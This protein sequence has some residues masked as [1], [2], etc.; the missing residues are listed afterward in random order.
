MSVDP[1]FWSVF[2]IGLLL[3][4]RS[5]RESL[6]E[7]AARIDAKML[8]RPDLL[9]V[10]LTPDEKATLIESKLATIKSVKDRTGLDLSDAYAVVDYWSR[11][12][13]DERSTA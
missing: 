12:P 8:N 3:W 1:I 10:A 13:N 7:R 9:E 4:L 2:G 6:Q 5:T 11:H